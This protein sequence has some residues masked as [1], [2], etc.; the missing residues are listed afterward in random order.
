LPPAARKKFKVA[1]PSP[2]GNQL[3][4]GSVPAP[5]G[6]TAGIVFSAINTGEG[7]DQLYAK[8]PPTE[9]FINWSGTFDSIDAQGDPSEFTA[10][11]STGEGTDIFT[12][13]DTAFSDLSATTIA[14]TFYSLLQ[15]GASSIGVLLSLS[16]S[17][18]DIAYE[19]GAVI[20]GGGI[21]FGT[22][23]DLGTITAG[24]NAVPLAVPEPSGMVCVAIGLLLM[25]A[26]QGARGVPSGSGRL[27]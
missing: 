12:L 24:I 25:A 13:S 6:A 16:G 20:S 23:S 17:Q 5:K 4:F 2:T 19:P 3:V 21:S 22:T 11:I 10:G 8:D 14:G 18:I 26:L 7:N 9:A 15:P 27:A 1:E